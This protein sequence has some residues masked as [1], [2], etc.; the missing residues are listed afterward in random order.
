MTTWDNGDITKKSPN[1]RGKFWEITYEITGISGDTGGTIT[2]ADLKKLKNAHVSA[3]VNLAAVST[4]L[5]G[6][7]VIVT[8]TDPTAGHVV[9]LTVFGIRN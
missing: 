1:T 8:Y 9:Y 2:V 4:K 7:Q 6:N 3:S 5:S